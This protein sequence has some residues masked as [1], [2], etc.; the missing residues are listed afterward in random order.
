MRKSKVL[1][2]RIGR[3]KGLDGEYF[4]DM[5]TP[6]PESLKNIFL[7]DDPEDFSENSPQIEI[8]YLKKRSK[9]FVIKFK[10]EAEEL[11]GKFLSIKKWKLDDGNFWIDDL[12]ECE[13][14]D[15]RGNFLGNV[16]EIDKNMPQTWIKIEKDGRKFSFPFVKDIV[17]NVFLEKKQI[18]IK[19]FNH[20]FLRVE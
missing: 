1:F 12:C 19:V 11:T 18:V 8:A 16:C 15:T 17:E 20:T 10:K 6:Y 14:V 7:E 4:F 3:R 9:R 13:V 2:G 5:F